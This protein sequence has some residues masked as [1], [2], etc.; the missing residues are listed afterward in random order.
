VRLQD[1]PG[2]PADFTCSRVGGTIGHSLMTCNRYDQ[3]MHFQ[4]AQPVILDG[5]PCDGDKHNHCPHVYIPEDGTLMMMVAWLATQTYSPRLTK[6]CI[7]A[8]RPYH[9]SRSETH[10][11]VSLRRADVPCQASI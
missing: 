8:E 9:F 1:G 6:V 4:S 2:T 3:T 10:P 11:S 7:I 5:E